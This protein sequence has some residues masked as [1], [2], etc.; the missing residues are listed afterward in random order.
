M[1]RLTSLRRA[2]FATARAE[3]IGWQRRGAGAETLFA[4]IRVDEDADGGFGARSFRRTGFEARRKDFDLP[5]GKGDLV[6]AGGR[7]FSVIEVEPKPAVGS[8]ILWVEVGNG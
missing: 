8:I 4:A 6:T 2:L 3:Q 7:T 5:P 1:E